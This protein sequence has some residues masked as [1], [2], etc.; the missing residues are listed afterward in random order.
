MWFLKFF[1]RRFRNNTTKTR[2]VVELFQAF[3]WTCDECGRDNFTRAI[4]IPV[5][6]VQDNMMTYE[7]IERLMEGGDGTFVAAPDKVKCFHCK[8]E[9]KTECV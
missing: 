8:M 3:S 6:T 7:E 1:L 9:F 5:E 4:T 2:K